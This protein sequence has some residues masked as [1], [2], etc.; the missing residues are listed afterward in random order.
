LELKP[1]TRQS[2]I[3]GKQLLLFA[4]SR[5]LFLRKQESIDVQSPTRSLY[6]ILSNHKTE[7]LILLLFL[8]VRLWAVWSGRL[9][10]DSD[11]AIFGI[12]TFEILHGNFPVYYLGQNYLGTFQAWALF[13]F[14][15]LFGSTTLAIRMLALGEGLVILFVWRWIFHKWGLEK[16]WIYFAVLFAL[17]PEF[18]F[19]WT[20]KSRAQVE[21]LLLGSLWV[22]GWVH[23]VNPRGTINT[24]IRPWALF[25]LLSGLCWWTSPLTVQ[26][27]FPALVASL[28]DRALRRKLFDGVKLFFHSSPASKVWPVVL[29]TF[30][31]STGLLIL[32]PVLSED[33]SAGLMLYHLRW[34][35]LGL[36]FVGLIGLLFFGRQNRPA[37]GVLAFALG[38][39]AGQLPAM[40]ALFH[41][42]GNSH[43]MKVLELE[44]ISLNIH[45]LLLLTLGG[46]IGI[47]NK[48]LESYGLPLLIAFTVVVIYLL[49][50]CF[51]AAF[52]F[53]AGQGK[54]RI[55]VGVKYALAGIVLAAV[56]LCLV[57][58]KLGVANRYGLPMM[59][60]ALILLGW[61][62]RQLGRIN[63]FFSGGVLFFLLLVH[64]LSIAQLQTEEVVFPSAIPREDHRVIEFLKRQSIPSAVTSLTSASRG[65]WD[66]YRL[67]WFSGEEVIF[68]P[69]FHM[70]RVERY[71]RRVQRAD[72]LAVVTKIPEGVEK[73][74]NPKFRRMLDRKTVDGA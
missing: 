48:H 52:L 40:T 23:L 63:R 50:F 73:V 56:F 14:Q 67:S 19:S 36:F 47:L 8:T 35:L 60:M 6:Q 53:R 68:H 12:M 13:P 71:R 20:M 72:R 57:Q 11:E 42:L 1:G 22:A 74:F 27:G 25:G 33:S 17:P 18:V 49:F 21:T 45:H 34:L 26:F 70:P 43:E 16:C 69:V 39:F 29:F 32:R 61:F 51:L 59:F 3:S 30:L 31:L 58:E 5:S 55:P 38:L 37:R 24:R 9:P 2:L 46:F 44:K 65:Y 54:K 15:W 7:I 66:A 4:S 10:V 64:F 41:A 62:F 28:W